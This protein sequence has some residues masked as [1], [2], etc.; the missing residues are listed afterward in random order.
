MANPDTFKI[1]VTSQVIWKDVG[2]GTIIFFAAIVAILSELYE[3]AA[4]DGASS[5]RR[6]WHITLPGMM[7][8]ISMLLILNVGT[9]LTVGFEQMLR[10]SP[11]WA[12]T[13]PRCWTPSCT[14]AA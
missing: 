6:M 2:W 7:P 1:L 4:T 3:S 13:R 5:W 10:S 12:P 8:V 14:S 9:A 11:R